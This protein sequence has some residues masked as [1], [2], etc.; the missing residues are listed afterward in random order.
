MLGKIAAGGGQILGGS[1]RIRNP[2]PDESERRVEE[3]SFSEGHTVNLV[4]GLIVLGGLR[5]YVKNTAN[6]VLIVRIGS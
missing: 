4:Y 3:C 1:I 5:K 6:F 2:F